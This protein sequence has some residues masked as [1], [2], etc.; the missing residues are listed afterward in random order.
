MTTLTNSWPF[1]T[2]RPA[3]YPLLSLFNRAAA[4]ADCNG[5]L[6]TAVHWYE[7][8]HCPVE[9]TLLSWVKKEQEKEAVPE[10]TFS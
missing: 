7:D 8:F 4:S 2:P 10:D 6:V 9:W 5:G 1:L 3:I